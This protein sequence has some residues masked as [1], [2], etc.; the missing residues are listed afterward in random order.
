MLLLVALAH[1]NR[2]VFPFCIIWSLYPAIFGQAT[3]SAFGRVRLALTVY[4]YLKDRAGKGQGCWPAVKT[5]ASD[6]DLSRSTIKRALHDLTKAGLVEKE[7][8]YRE[9][10]SHTSNR[11]I[12][13]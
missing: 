2:G 13:K 9:N 10:G 1:L 4:M 11:L 5:I 7:T 6:L 12:L 8:R 3:P